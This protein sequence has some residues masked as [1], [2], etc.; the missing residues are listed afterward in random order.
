MGALTFLTNRSVKEAADL[1]LAVEP[2]DNSPSDSA[3][4]ATGE[5]Q[6]STGKNASQVGKV[7]D[8]AQSV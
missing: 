7:A 1:S 8:K 6:E 3:V 4:T 2:T 5:V